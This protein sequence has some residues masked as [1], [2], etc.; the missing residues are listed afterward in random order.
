M[1]SFTE[2]LKHILVPGGHITN[3]YVLGH[4]CNSFGMG[5]HE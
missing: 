4:M 2:F 5:E 1:H 3:I